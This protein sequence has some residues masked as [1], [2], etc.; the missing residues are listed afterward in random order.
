MQIFTDGSQ[1]ET[2]INERLQKTYTQ[3]LL[4]GVDR[5]R[6]PVSSGSFQAFMDE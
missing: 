4:A 2:E 1:K 5:K 6:L 3:L